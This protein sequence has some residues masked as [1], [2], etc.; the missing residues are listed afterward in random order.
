MPPEGN[1][2]ASGSPWMSWRPEKRTMGLPSPSRLRKVSCFSAVSPRIGWN[3]W[4]KWV[5]PWE[6]AHSFMPWATSLAIS[7]SS[8]SLFSMTLRSLSKT[9]FDRKRFIAALLKVRQPKRSIALVSAFL[10][11]SMP[12]PG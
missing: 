1:E 9:A 6:S 3:Q 5:A 8:L 10:S 12:A 4:V 11:D 2:E 7:A